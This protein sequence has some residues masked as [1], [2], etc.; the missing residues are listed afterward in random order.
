[1]TGIRPLKK[2]GVRWTKGMIRHGVDAVAQYASLAN[3]KTVLWMVDPFLRI[4]NYRAKD[5]HTI[6]ISRATMRHMGVAHG[7]YI[8]LIHR[9][10]GEVVMRRASERRIK[11][12]Y[13]MLRWNAHGDQMK[14]AAQASRP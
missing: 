1:M 2:C 5:T 13:T 4:I 12:A 9:R 7:D 14:H 11:N 3:L 6:T 8:E 10:N